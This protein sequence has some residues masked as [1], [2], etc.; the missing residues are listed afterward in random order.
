[1]IWKFPWLQCMDSSNPV[2]HDSCRMAYFLLHPHT[3]LEHLLSCT[4]ITS[5]KSGGVGMPS[6]MTGIYILI[7]N[8][9]PNFVMSLDSPAGSSELAKISTDVII[10]KY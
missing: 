3:S 6:A 7:R 1:M 2:Y 8:Y 10:F 9:H 4:G 5:S